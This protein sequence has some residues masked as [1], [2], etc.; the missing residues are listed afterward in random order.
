MYLIKF[1]VLFIESRFTVIRID[2]ET[3]CVDRA[4]LKSAI[5]RYIS[6][7]IAKYCTYI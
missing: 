4:C 6:G 3:G 7:F 2:L 5:R 1:I